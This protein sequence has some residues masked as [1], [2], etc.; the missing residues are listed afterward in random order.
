M[1][2]YFKLGIEFLKFLKPY[3]LRESDNGIWCSNKPW[4]TKNQIYED[5]KTT[6]ELL[7]LETASFMSEK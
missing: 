1:P 7:P 6:K 4:Q 3:I 2:Y 5:F